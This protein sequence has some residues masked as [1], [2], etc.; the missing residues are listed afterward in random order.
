[1]D[2]GS[3]RRSRGRRTTPSRR[4][5]ARFNRHPPSVS[6]V[7][8]MRVSGYA[9][10]SAIIEPASSE[11]SRTR[12]NRV[13]SASGFLMVLMSSTRAR[14]GPT[15]NTGA[16][17]WTTS[18]GAFGSAAPSSPIRIVPRSNPNRSSSR[19]SR[20]TA[21]ATAPTRT[22]TMCSTPCVMRLST[23][24][25]SAVPLVLPNGGGRSS[26]RPVRS[27]VKFSFAG[28]P[29][30]AL[31][32]S[33]IAV[34]AESPRI[35]ARSGESPGGRPSRRSRILEVH[36]EQTARQATP[37]GQACRLRRI[38]RST[39]DGVNRFTEPGCGNAVRRH[40]RA[41]EFDLPVDRRQ[42]PPE[43]GELRFGCHRAKCCP[44]PRSTDCSPS[45]ESR[46]R[47]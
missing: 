24:R 2:T 36:R 33:K 29:L 20:N 42:S 40:L 26:A 8:C 17:A 28:V 3:A 30:P 45:E 47:G 39:D 7:A 14:H 34:H 35:R 10:P 4:R 1:M 32:T 13:L 46:D 22:S 37:D 9:S 16:A 15:S 18:P 43:T 12:P 11:I 19:A 31:G 41:L 44:P 21:L 5:P 27:L 25:G 38:A 23:R 6:R